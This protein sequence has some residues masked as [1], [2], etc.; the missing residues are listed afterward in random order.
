MDVKSIL[1]NSEDA[2]P[3]LEQ[4]LSTGTVQAPTLPTV[5]ADA[6][7]YW[8][9]GASTVM[10]AAGFIYLAYGKKTNDVQKILIGL[11]LTVGSFFVF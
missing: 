9:M 5:T 2:L 1:L 10:G 7:T 11:A 8:K 3:T 4:N 6:S